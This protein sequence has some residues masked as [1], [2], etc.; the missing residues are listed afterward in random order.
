MGVLNLLKVV[1]ETRSGFC[2]VQEVSQFFSFLL[3]PN[4][5]S[6]WLV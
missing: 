5:Y 2:K 3:K 1:N 4:V 6:V